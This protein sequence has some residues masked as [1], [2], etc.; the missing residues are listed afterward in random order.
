MEGTSTD[1]ANSLWGP[2]SSA[3]DRCVVCDD[4][5]VACA[6]IILLDGNCLLMNSASV[7]NE[8]VDQCSVRR[9]LSLSSS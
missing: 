9:T 6:C 1:F 7:E 5:I 8:F 3:V 2:L 4:S